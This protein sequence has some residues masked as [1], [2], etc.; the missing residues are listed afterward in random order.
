MGV[1]MRSIL[2]DAESQQLRIINQLALPAELRYL[3]LKT[4]TETF[5]AIKN[6]AVRGAPAIAVC[7]AFALYFAA[8]ESVTRDPAALLEATRDAREALLRLRPTAVNLQQVTGRILQ[9]ASALEGSA[10][11][12]RAHLLELAQEAAERA[13]ETNL[14]IARYGA[15]LLHDGDEIL[16]H[17]NTG[18]LAAVDYGTALGVIRMA[19][20]QGKRVHVYVTET[21]P[22]LQGSRLTA[23]ELQQYGIPYDIVVDSAAGYLLRTGK[24]DR[25]LFGAD[26]V[27]ANGDVVNKVGT[28]LLALAAY[29]NGIPAYSAFPLD[30]VDF[31]SPSAEAIPIEERDPSEVLALTYRG[32]PAAPEGARARNYAFDVTPHRLLSGL[33]TDRGILYPPFFRNLSVLKPHGREE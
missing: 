13:V 22:C 29:D 33:I 28:Y 1:W 3:D 26:R 10:D 25:V 23:W 9:Q 7:G 20:E 30:S 24:V 18:A 32:L 12:L 16:H 21:R 15:E 6:M 11:D 31:D 17:C 14:L 2:W 27:A 5:E 4:F 19:H 8:R